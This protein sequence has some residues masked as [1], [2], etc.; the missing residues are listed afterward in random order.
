MTNERGFFEKTTLDP[1]AG[2][3]TT[4]K[5][6]AGISNLFGGTE[7]EQCVLTRSRKSFFHVGPLDWKDVTGQ[8]FVGHKIPKLGRTLKL[9]RKRRLRSLR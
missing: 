9:V 2:S 3:P 5:S 7:M 4:G 6:V 8:E 1:K